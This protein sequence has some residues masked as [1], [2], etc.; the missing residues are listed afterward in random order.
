MNIK[1]YPNKTLYLALRTKKT[2]GDLKKLSDE[3]LPIRFGMTE[4]LH[5]LI[6]QGW[7]VEGCSIENETSIFMGDVDDH[8]YSYIYVSLI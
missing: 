2:D 3:Y 4:E 8:D 7:T 1:R 5:N 6:E